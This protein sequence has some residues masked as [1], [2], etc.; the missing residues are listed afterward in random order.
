MHL[1]DIDTQLRRARREPLWVPGPDTRLLDVRG[2]ALYP[3]LPHRLPF[4]LIDA[5]TAVDLSLGAIRCASRIDPATPLLEG[6]FPGRPTWPG[7]LLVEA[8][9]QCGACFRV[10]E[11]GGPPELN[12]FTGCRAVF[13]RPVGPGDELTL[14]SVRVGV[15]DGAF[16]RGVAQ[17]MRGDE[18][19][20]VAELN[21]ATLDG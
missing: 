15:Y 19:C 2:A 17:V 14:L 16:V 13:L 8:M 4:L 12:F 3:L 20:A 10:L 21:A 1:A 11:A 18:V 6:H 7:V 9:A 5:V